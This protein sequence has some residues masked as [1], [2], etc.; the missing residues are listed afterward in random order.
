MAETQLRR[1][2]FC[3]LCSVEIRAVSSFVGALGKLLFGGL[4]FVKLKRFLTL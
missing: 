2:T 3:S 4:W 1:A